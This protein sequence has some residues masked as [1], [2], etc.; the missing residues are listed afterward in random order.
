MLMKRT[1]LWQ[2][3]RRYSYMAQSTLKLQQ[4]DL[5]SQGTHIDVP[6]EAQ[7]LRVDVSLADSKQTLGHLSE[8]LRAQNANINE[9]DFYTL[10]GAI[11]PES[12]ALRN[13]NNLPFIM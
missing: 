4:L 12:E 3:S 10:D 9:V 6:F 8:S 11:I 7:T 1:L 5:H 13:R 2:A